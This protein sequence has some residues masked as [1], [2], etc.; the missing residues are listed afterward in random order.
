MIKPVAHV[1]EMPCLASACLDSL[2]DLEQQLLDAQALIEA[3]LRDQWRKT[4]PPVYASVDLRNAG[5]KLAP[6]DTNLFPAG[7]N[8][9]KEEFVPLA[10]QAVQEVLDR[11]APGCRRV[12]LI[13]ENHTR[14]QFYF[15]NLLSL[16]DIFCQAGFEVRIGSLLEELAGK[17]ELDLASGRRIVLEKVIRQE[18]QL[19]TDGF[20]PCLILLNND[21]SNGIPDIFKGIKQLILPMMELG[22][23]R[24]LKSNHFKEYQQVCHELAQLIHCDAW[25]LNPLFSSCSGVNFLKREGEAMLVEQSR[26]LL[27]DIQKKYDE[28]AIKEKP[29]VVIKADSGTYGMGILTVHDPA[30]LQQLNRK[31]RNDMRV[32]KG[33]RAIEQVIIQE[34]VYTFERWNEATAEPVVYLIGQYVIGGF[35]RVHRKR[36]VSDNLNSPGMQFEPLPF[37]KACNVPTLAN[38]QKGQCANRFY[39]YGLVARLA[40]LAA[41]REQAALSK[42]GLAHE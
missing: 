35:Y 7:F 15:E 40:V 4:P 24:R 11:L 28:Y 20:L 19:L 27:A 30:Q 5:F 1:T 16:Q 38:R 13:A 14:N 37:L 25:L 31:E 22:W 2:H 6:V 26:L 8:N 39:I 9:L 33:N 34:G 36:G 41:A 12:L 29:Y 17:R 32:A 42:Q 18:Q 10:V 21:L 3:W 23:H